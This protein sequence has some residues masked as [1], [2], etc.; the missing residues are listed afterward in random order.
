MAVAMPLSLAACLKK[1]DG[2]T[3][4]EGSKSVSET[5][6]ADKP[7]TDHSSK[8]SKNTS[9][10][11]KLDVMVIDA[12]DYVEK[13][14]GKKS[15]IFKKEYG[16]NSVSY[17]W[18]KSKS[19]KPAQNMDMDVTVNGLKIKCGSDVRSLLEN[20]YELFEFGNSECSEKIISAHEK[21]GPFSLRSSE[22]GKI[23]NCFLA[24]T[25]DSEKTAKECVVLSMSF[26]GDCDGVSYRGLTDEDD[27]KDVL[28]TLGMPVGGIIISGN[29]DAVPGIT[30]NYGN[31]GAAVE[32]V[33]YYDP[34]SDSTSFYDIELIAD[35]QL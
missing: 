32:V 34:A 9:A 17:V 31:E 27:F 21:D 19:E 1:G 30:V 18:D 7:S 24:N 3:T 13:I 23:I 16:S 33:F 2:G 15:G 8:D 26:I 14:I 10:E 35:I 11:E 29:L 6:D 5:G 22:N 25:S 28:K 20:G 4:A 12:V